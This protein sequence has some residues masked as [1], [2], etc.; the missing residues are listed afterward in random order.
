[1]VKSAEA[2]KTDP[3]VSGPATSEAAVSVLE[4]M[5][6]VDR[7]KR[8]GIPVTV[9]SLGLA[10]ALHFYESGDIGR[11]EDVRK[12]FLSAKTGVQGLT[13]VSPYDLRRGE[14]GEGLEDPKDN[15]AE[16]KGEA[17][18]EEKSSREEARNDEMSAGSCKKK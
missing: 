1:M 13:L 5:T 6:T 2:E 9:Q 12:N 10:E 16:P 17:A 7:E 18:G 3:G 14:T 4:R 11:K 15:A 8:G